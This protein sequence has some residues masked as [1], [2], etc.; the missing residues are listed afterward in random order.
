MWDFVPN[1]Y[2]NT[3]WYASFPAFIFTT[4]AEKDYF[5]EPQNPGQANVI[6]GYIRLMKEIVS[7]LIYIY[8]YIKIYMC[9]YICMYINII[10]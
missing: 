7:Q 9:V 3:M 2:F 4:R 5:L 6:L 1:I 8:I 10:I